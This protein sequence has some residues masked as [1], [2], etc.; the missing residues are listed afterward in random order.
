M[1]D[2]LSDRGILEEVVAAWSSSKRVGGV[3][4]HAIVRRVYLTVRILRSRVELIDL[5]CCF[6]IYVNRHALSLS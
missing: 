1:Q 5:C 6:R 4:W 2:L 3:G